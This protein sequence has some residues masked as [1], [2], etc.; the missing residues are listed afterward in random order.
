MID[1]HAH[2]VLEGTFGAAGRHGPEIVTDAAGVQSFR[3]GDYVFTGVRYEGSAF[4][5]VDVRLAAMETAGIEYQVLSPNPLTYFHHI[6]AGLADGFCRRHNDL[7]AALVADHPDRLGG[8]AALPMQD[9]A[10]AVAELRRSV[11][12][13]GLLGAEVG[14][15]FGRPLDDPALDDL[16]AAA[17]ELDVPLFLHPGFD[18]VDRPRVDPRMARF[19]LDLVIGF[20]A[21]ETLAVAT[22]IFGGVLDR[23]PELDVCLSHG[24]GAVPF[25][26]GRMGRAARVRSWAPPEL[27]ADGGFED[28]LARL[29]FDSH[30]HDPRALAFLIEVFGDDRLVGGTNFAGWDQGHPP[31]DADLRTRLTGNARRLLRLSRR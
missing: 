27:A 28:R 23:H 3:T 25:L 2:V 22:L 6:D 30:V 8:L 19:D 1:V 11:G 5:D 18:G 12:E 10:R 4:L 21:E 17:V 7:L 24:G 31:D 14:T 16:Y 9:P 13:L 15:E 20:A 29:W 26:I